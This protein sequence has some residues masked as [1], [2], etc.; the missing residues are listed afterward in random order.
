MNSKRELDKLAKQSERFER[1][2]NKYKPT[3]HKVGEKYQSTSGMTYEIIGEKYLP[4]DKTGE[5]RRTLK[6]KTNYA[7]SPILEIPDTLF[8]TE[9]LRK[10]PKTAKKAAPKKNK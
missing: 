8:D 1:K 3:K 5:R 6:I 9:T 2:V 7:P 4:K 10:I